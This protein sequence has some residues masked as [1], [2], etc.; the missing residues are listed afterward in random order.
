MGV[1]LGHCH[2]G[3]LGFEFRSAL[4]PAAWPLRTCACSFCRKH[5]AVYTSDPS[6]SVRFT[7]REPGLISR[8][9]FGLK[10]ADFIFCG[11]CGIFLGAVMETDG[12]TFAVTNVNTLDPR[13]DGLPAAPAM[14]YEDE[15]SEA[16]SSRRASRW[17]PV[18]RS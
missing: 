15:T 3:A 13:P 1:H 6:G 11:R 8:Y 12:R 17:T 4:E 14:S 10:T 7:H 5:G 2:C 9:R 16:R 18:L